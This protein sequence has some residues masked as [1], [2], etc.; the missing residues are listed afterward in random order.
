MFSD[1]LVQPAQTFCSVWRE[2]ECSQTSSHSTAAVCV[3]LPLASST[4]T[5]LA[6]LWNA[7]MIIQWLNV[8]P[9]SWP[10]PTAVVRSGGAVPTLSLDTKE[11][12]LHS[13]NAAI[14]DS[15]NQIMYSLSGDLCRI[16]KHI[17]LIVHSS[18]YHS[19]VRE[20]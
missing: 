4:H 3:T 12:L 5:P 9:L 14:L 15:Y 11:L 17:L 8:T 10:S 6:Q 18:Y 1:S 7:E 20:Q 13:C 19:A 16:I 2:L